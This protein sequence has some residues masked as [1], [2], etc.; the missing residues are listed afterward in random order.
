[1]A[2]TNDDV[3]AKY[4]ATLGRFDGLFSHPPVIDTIEKVKRSA[5]WTLKQGAPDDVD[6]AKSLLADIAAL[7][8]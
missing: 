5:E 1:M 6:L 7:E 4:H 2:I 8:K 3:I